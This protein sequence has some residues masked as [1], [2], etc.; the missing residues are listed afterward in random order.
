MSAVDVQVEGF[1]LSP[2]QRRAWRLAAECGPAHPLRAGVA[3]ALGQAGADDVLDALE[4]VAARHEVLRTAFRLPPG[5]TVPVQVILPAL[6]A[7]A[8]LVDD[9]A[10][11]EDADLDARFARL[12]ARPFGLDEPP[13]LADVVADGGGGVVLL[14]A[15]PAL[16]A[17]A[18]TLERVAREVDAE[19]RGEDIP[20]PDYQ[21]ADLAGWLSG[22]ADEPDEDARAWW[23]AHEPPP[24]RLPFERPAVPGAPFAPARAAVPLPAEVAEGVAR[25]A[26]EAGT[27]AETLL[28]AAWST[29]LWRY[30][31]APLAVGVDLD[32]R[33]YEGLD[34]VAGPLARVVPLRV[35]PEEGDRFAAQLARVAAAME[36]AVHRQE[37]FAWPPSHGAETPHAAYAF[38]WRAPRES[39]QVVARHACIE[40]FA[41][42]LEALAGEADGDL[43]M[44]ID[45]DP[46]RVDADA[47]AEVAARLADLLAEVAWDADRPVER[48]PL[49]ARPSSPESIESTES[50]ESTAPAAVDEAEDVVARFEAWAAEHPDQP[51]VVFESALLSYGELDARANQLAHHLRALGVGPEAR[52]AVF[53]ER[54][55]EAI[56]AILATL[57]A[58]GAYVPLDLREPPARLA[59]RLAAA[60]PRV[61]T[62]GAESP[63]LEH[64]DAVR[65]DLSADR[66]A[67]ARLPRTRPDGEAPSASLA[68]LLF[69]SG[70]TG[71]PKGVG[72]E[73]RQLAAYVD[74]VLER[75]ALPAGARFASVT[76]LAA[77]LG[78]TAVFGALCGGGTLHLV[79]EATLM[80]P[81]GFGDYLRRHRVDALKIVPG[82]L[83]ALL[84]GPAPE[85]VLP[86]RALVLGGEA[87]GWEL[88][89]RVRALA[90]ECAV[91]NHYGPT[92]TTVGVCAV[93]LDGEDAGRLAPAPPIGRPLRHARLHVLNA[94]GGPAAAWE[95]GELFAGGGQVARGYLGNPAA[96]AERFLPDRFAAEPGARMYRT[97]DQVRWIAPAPSD[98]HSRTPALTHSRTAVLEF[99]GR[100]DRQVKVR[101][102]RVEPGEVEAALREHPDVADA[103]VVVRHDPPQGTRLVAYVVPRS[104]AAPVDAA[105]R[106][107]LAARLPAAAL[108]A[109]LVPL[110]RIPLGPN[111]KPDL[112]QLPAERGHAAP[113]V[114]PETEAERAIAA[115]WQELLGVEQVGRD[116]NFFDLGGHSLLMVQLHHEMETRLGTQV[117]I[118]EMFSH[119]TVRALAQR[120]A[121]G[122]GADTMDEARGRGARQRASREARGRRRKETRG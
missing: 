106:A 101:G 5:R 79:P 42:R 2:L 122:G 62:T 15:L 21:Y 115:L 26:R 45:H 48:I 107:H 41:L 88:V 4:R 99:L 39:A 16:A 46:L 56:V 113:A 63:P 7:R 84:A 104:D 30:A 9:G 95:P 118:L 72:V 50:T 103:L 68:Y 36:G 117:P 47:A 120:A 25:R 119:P 58:G 70:S 76:T 82:H 52:V 10:D 34:G 77:D 110:R 81:A 74:G 89:N 94:G 75:L 8:A 53:L 66:D 51:A 108:P 91:I 90:P 80:D 23:A 44:W 19:L 57:K 11:G 18:R 100:A 29:L 92:E 114:A 111:G 35:E 85:R 14:L 28:L 55:A 32:G 37:H 98:A 73:R 121:G 61:L 60:A 40:R 86:A 31:R 64:G 71:E 27:T 1:Q 49:A 105:L 33:V 24:A 12:L 59:R 93:R 3:V 22:F 109:A 102:H 54:S 69:T 17:D 13:L 116:D 87:A 67:I 6:D 112:S 96:T 97:G 78:N 83:R 43:R 65:V 20:A 38:A